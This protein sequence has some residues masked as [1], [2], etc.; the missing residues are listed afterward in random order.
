MCCSK[1]EVDRFTKF[2]YFSL[3]QQ[4]PSIA[5]KEATLTILNYV[6]QYWRLT[7]AITILLSIS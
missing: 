6:E 3:F 2:Y 4:T 7:K 5:K 1:T